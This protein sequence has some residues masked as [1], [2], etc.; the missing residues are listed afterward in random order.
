MIF[1]KEISKINQK[2]VDNTHN[3]NQ[4]ETK[5]ISFMTEI[6]FIVVKQKL[7]KCTPT[8]NDPRSALTLWR[9]TRKIRDCLV[10]TWKPIQLFIGKLGNFLAKCLCICWKL[11][12]ILFIFK[13]TYKHIYWNFEHNKNGTDLNA[14]TKTNKSLF[15]RN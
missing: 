10:D 8:R 1:W 5:S 6:I 14:K 15:D 13:K 11:Q 3:I 7:K 4:N 12:K 2:Q 9:N